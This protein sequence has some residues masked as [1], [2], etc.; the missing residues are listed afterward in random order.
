MSTFQAV[1]GI[2][3]AL[4]LLYWMYGMMATTV[5]KWSKKA[6]VTKSGKT[7]Q[8]NLTPGEVVKC[9]V[10]LLQVCVVRESL[11]RTAGPFPVLSIISAVLMLLRVINV[12]LLP[13]NSYVMFATIWLFL[14]GLLMHF[15]IYGF[16][17]AD[18]VKLY[19]FSWL[20]IILSFLFPQFVAFFMRSQI[21]YKMQQA[22]KEE[23]FH[24]HKDTTFK[25]R[26]SK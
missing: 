7:R 9:Y 2:L 25:Q 17:T 13:I 3:A 20:I 1:G 12:F 14:L 10:P 6:I 21:P 11:Y 26:P 15:I 4:L 18:A 22:H 19:G 23:T 5:L 8:P 16:V 24:E